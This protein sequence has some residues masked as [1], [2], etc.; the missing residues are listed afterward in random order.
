[1]KN[2]FR[3]IIVDKEKYEGRELT[4]DEKFHMSIAVEQVTDINKLG[5]I[6]GIHL[7]DGYNNYI[8]D[9]DVLKYPEA[10]L[11]CLVRATDECMTLNSIL[12]FTKD[13]N[14]TENATA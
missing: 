11:K 12:H 1:M 10:L 14:S 3:I 4:E 9:P 5:I 13:T 2:M 7:V 8:V 6:N